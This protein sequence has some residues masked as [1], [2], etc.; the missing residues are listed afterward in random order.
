MLGRQN[1]IFV[2]V[3]HQEVNEINT[4]KILISNIQLFFYIYAQKYL[5][6]FLTVYQEKLFSC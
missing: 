4:I 3:C 6:Y 1:I 2:A 5:L